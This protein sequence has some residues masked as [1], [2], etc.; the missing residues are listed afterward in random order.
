MTVRR[1]RVRPRRRRPAP[2]RWRPLACLAAAGLALCLPDRPLA[3]PALPSEWRPQR[4]VARPSTMQPLPEA[5]PRRLSQAEFDQVWSQTKHAM[6]ACNSTVDDVQLN[7][8]IR[9]E[10]P[11]DAALQLVRERCQR[12]SVEVGEVALPASARDGVEIMLQQAREACQRSMVEKQLGL[13]ALRDWPGRRRTVWKPTRPGSGSRRSHEARST[14]EPASPPPPP[15]RAFTWR[16]WR[17]PAP[18]GVFQGSDAAG[19]VSSSSAVR[20]RA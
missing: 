20:S 17:W 12:G 14:V 2:D 6:A 1:V 8:R 19:S 3:V 13:A 5:S 7:W 4:V 16:N 9:G 11:G 18:E 10:V 15:P